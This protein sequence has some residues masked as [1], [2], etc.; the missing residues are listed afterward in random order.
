MKC[1]IANH[2]NKKHFSQFWE[3]IRKSKYKGNKTNPSI[4]DNICGDQNIANH[5]K[6]KFCDL[7]NSRNGVNTNTYIKQ[8]SKI[9]K[10]CLENNCNS[11]HKITYLDVKSATKKLK[12]D[13]IDSIY[14]ITTENISYASNL[15]IELLAK[16][17]DSMLI[18]G[19]SLSKLNK[20]VIKPILKNKRKSQ[21]DSNNYRGIALSSLIL[22]LLEYVIIDKIQD[23]IISSDYQFA[24]KKNHS[25]VMCNF[26]LDQTLQ[27]YRNNNT[28]VY[29]VFLDATKAFDLIDHEQLFKTLNNKDICPLFIRL[30]MILYKFNN[31][32]VQYNKAIS[33]P[34]N[35]QTGVKQGS[36]L[37]AY[38]FTLYMDDL[39]KLL[40]DTQV[41]CFVGN[42]LI[43][44]L[45]YADDV[46]LIAPSV[47]AMKILLEKCEAFSRSHHVNFN[48]NK[49]SLLFFNKSRRCNNCPD[50][51]IKFCGINI[52][53]KNEINYLGTVLKNDSE[54]H[55]TD[56]CI[57]D[58]KIRSNV[59]INEFS[60]LDT[61]ARAKLFKTQAMNFFSLELLDLDAQY[62]NKLLV[63][64]RVCSRKILKIDKKSHCNLIA[65]LIA[66][67]NPL[68]IIEERFLNFH[69]KLL[70]HSNSVIRHLINFTISNNFS[71]INKNLIDILLK[72]S[73]SYDKLFLNKSIKINDNSELSWRIPIIS[74]LLQ[75]RESL[76]N[77][78]LN[79]QEIELLI[80]DLCIN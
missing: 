57:N 3:V 48:S 59:I 36:V 40:L 18:H 8:D 44:T 13:K 6:I 67:K 34:F 71:N 20:S 25:T 49:S 31:A 12:K 73:I 24:Y 4:I 39:V 54:L 10:K 72:H 79:F 38:L 21:T 66:C 41:G 75:A 50:L 74:E 55:N 11:N 23:N 42:K 76:I 63:A 9:I 19:F 78:N 35:M 28:D 32:I 70:N 29:C 26:V 51:N 69:R 64:W 5:F 52:P 60:H 17:F 80:R 43:N 15:L 14:D 30:I 58:L 47:G 61:A 65:P 16:I 68:L 2:L 27:Y 46:V 53:V 33:G 56:K 37:S 7:Y 1:N 22:K 45:V 77:I 62:I